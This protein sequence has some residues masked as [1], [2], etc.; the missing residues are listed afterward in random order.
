MLPD[1]T[2]VKNSYVSALSLWCCTSRGRK[3]PNGDGFSQNGS[4]HTCA[5]NPQRA[6]ILISNRERPSHAVLLFNKFLA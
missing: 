3:S 1:K 6:L 2:E 4:F 5:L